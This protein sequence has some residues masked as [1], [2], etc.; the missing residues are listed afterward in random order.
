MRVTTKLRQRQQRSMRLLCNL[1]L[2]SADCFLKLGRYDE[3]LKAI[4]EA[5]SIDCASNARVWSTLGRLYFQQGN[6][7]RAITAFQKGLVCDAHDVDCR[8]WLAKAYMEQK[9]YEV[10]EGLLDAVTKGNG[11]DSAEAWLVACYY[12]YQYG[13]SQ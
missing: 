10:A 8:L 3:A 6:I 11:W 4:E 1:W 9:L 2:L 12:Y 5:E 7:V 13:F